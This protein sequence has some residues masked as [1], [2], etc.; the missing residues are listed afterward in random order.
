MS[1]NITIKV[2]EHKVSRECRVHFR[3]EQK[4]ILI[5]FF[6]LSINITLD[7]SHMNLDKIIV[8]KLWRN[9]KSF[10][11]NNVWNFVKVMW[12]FFDKQEYHPKKNHNNFTFFQILLL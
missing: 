6:D 2:S 7:A 12:I 3:I 8:K 11:R 1:I 10:Y 5:I 9:F 4:L